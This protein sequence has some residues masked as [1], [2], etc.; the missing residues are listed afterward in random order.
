[1]D[2]SFALFNQVEVSINDDPQIGGLWRV[3]RDKGGN[4]QFFLN[5]E[6]DPTFGELTEAWYIVEVAA[7]RIELVYEDEDVNFKTLVFEKAI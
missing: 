3:T 2:F 5:F 7:D 6:N 4:L 1:M